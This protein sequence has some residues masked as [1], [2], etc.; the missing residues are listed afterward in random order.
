[1]ALLQIGRL[2][3]SLRSLSKSLAKWLCTTLI[4]TT[5]FSTVAY[6]W[7]PQIQIP[8]RIV[9]GMRFHMDSLS[10]LRDIFLVLRENTW[11]QIRVKGGQWRRQDRTGT[12]PWNWRRSKCGVDPTQHQ[13]HRLEWREVDVQI[14]RTVHERE[15]PH[16]VAFRW[17]LPSGSQRKSVMIKYSTTTSST[18][19]QGW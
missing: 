5:G 19:E 8:V 10:S 2:G 9:D 17:K 12:R 14:Q 3:H 4:W 15:L 6:G 1:M 11:K 18:K 13:G 16:L 7:V